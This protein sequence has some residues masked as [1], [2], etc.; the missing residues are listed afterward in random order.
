VDGLVALYERGGR[1]ENLEVVSIAVAEANE[2]ND[3]AEGAI[4]APTLLVYI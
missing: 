3:F 4:C 1:Y 2:A